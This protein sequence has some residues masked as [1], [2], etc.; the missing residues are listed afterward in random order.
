MFTSHFS[1]LSILVMHSFILCNMMGITA[2]L[3]AALAL[4][5]CKFSSVAR[6]PSASNA[7]L[8]SPDGVR[9]SANH[10]QGRIADIVKTKV[11]SIFK[12]NSED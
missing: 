8:L 1:S 2:I 7:P 4:K 3:L 5:A 12:V 10:S 6:S 11:E 9:S